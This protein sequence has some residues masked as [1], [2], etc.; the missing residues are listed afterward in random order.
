MSLGRLCSNLLFTASLPM[1]DA[2]ASHDHCGDSPEIS[3]EAAC[4][5]CVLARLTTRSN[6]YVQKSSSTPHQ[7]SAPGNPFQNEQKNDCPTPAS[8]DLK[9]LERERFPDQSGPGHEPK[10]KK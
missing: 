8:Q 9:P 5:L 10:E 7:E 6:T 3:M 2:T 4:I 1:E